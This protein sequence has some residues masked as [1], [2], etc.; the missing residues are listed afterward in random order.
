MIFDELE[1]YLFQAKNL[2]NPNDF[3]IFFAILYFFFIALKNN[4][5]IKKLFKKKKRGINDS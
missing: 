3:I 5:Y 1:F 4:F 2:K